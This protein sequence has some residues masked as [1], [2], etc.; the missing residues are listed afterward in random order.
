MNH[1]RIISVAASELI[2]LVF[3]DKVDDLWFQWYKNKA[4]CKALRHHLEKAAVRQANLR[5]KK[6]KKVCLEE[7][8]HNTRVERMVAEGIPRGSLCT[9]EELS[10]GIRNSRACSEIH[11]L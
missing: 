11:A 3:V 4:M 7:Q 8:D 5:L 6:A 1:K 10:R 9:F 2:R